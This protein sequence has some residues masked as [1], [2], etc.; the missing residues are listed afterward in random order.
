[1]WKSSSCPHDHLLVLMILNLSSW[2]ISHT[3][4]PVVRYAC[5]SRYYFLA[6]LINVIAEIYSPP[7]TSS[8]NGPMTLDLSFL[9]RQMDGGTY[10]LSMSHDHVFKPI[11]MFFTFSQITTSETTTA[12]ATKVFLKTQLSLIPWSPQIPL[13][14]FLREWREDGSENRDRLD[15]EKQRQQ[16]A[17]C[18]TRRREEKS[19]FDFHF[20]SSIVRDA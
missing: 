6:I 18:E 2:D 12:A 7:V 16:T 17:L 19:N 15:H 11:V 9:M 14:L 13:G 1:M 8:A 20:H 5:I 4:L 10:L 3:N